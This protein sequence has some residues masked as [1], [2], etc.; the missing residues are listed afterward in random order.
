VTFKKPALHLQG[1]SVFQ[2][3]VMGVVNI[4][5]LLTGELTITVT[6]CLILRSLIRIWTALH[7]GVHS[8][9][10]M[11]NALK[12][13]RVG[14]ES[15]HDV[16]CSECGTAVAYSRDNVEGGAPDIWLAGVS[17]ALL[18]HPN[19]SWLTGLKQRLKRSDFAANVAKKS[20]EKKHDDQEQVRVH[21]YT[22]TDIS[23]YHSGY[24]LG[25][26]NGGLMTPEALRRTSLQRERM[27]MHIRQCE[28]HGSAQCHAAR[29]E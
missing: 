28:A 11:F 20:G 8:A 27:H 29:S 18:D 12:D 14:Q 5:N 3:P 17:W 2:V 15:M 23:I 19:P 4:Q 21:C 6:S 7:R 9:E 26:E 1:S 16:Y 24:R 13:G 22:D 25:G 10:F